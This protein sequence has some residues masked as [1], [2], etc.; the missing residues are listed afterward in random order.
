MELN[1]A[2]WP[3]KEKEL[4]SVNRSTT[5][6]GPR[7]NTVLRTE[8]DDPKMKWFMID[9]V[10]PVFIPAL[11]ENEEPICTCCNKEFPNFVTALAFPMKDSPEARRIQFLTLNC[12]PK[13]A[14]SKTERL[15]HSREQA[16]NDKDDASKISDMTE[17]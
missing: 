6:F 11:S 8:I 16:R 2:V 5:E 3:R 10:S 1:L 12:E 9:I 17:I 13:H 15:L 7:C 4:P 14:A